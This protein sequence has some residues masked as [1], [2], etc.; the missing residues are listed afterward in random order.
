[1]F[2]CPFHLLSFHLQIDSGLLERDISDLV[3]P[4]LHW[5][6][7]LLHRVAYYVNIRKQKV[8]NKHKLT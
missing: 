7:S 2:C 6:F 1:M 3:E 5:P 8:F 4:S